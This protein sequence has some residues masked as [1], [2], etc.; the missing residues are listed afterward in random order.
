MN[1]YAW[2]SRTHQ[3]MKGRIVELKHKVSESMHVTGFTLVEMLVVL[4]MLSLLLGILVPGLGRVRAAARQTVCQSRLRQWAVAFEIYAAENNGFLPHADG[5]DRSGSTRPWT[6]EGRAD[7]DAGWVDVLPPLL[8]EKPWRE[9]ERYDYPGRSTVFQCPDTRLAPLDRYGYQPL[10]NGFFS[11]AM[12]SCL[13][14]DANCWPPYGSGE[15]NN[16]PSFLNTRLIKQPERVI[17]VFEQLL[18][19]D[20]GF[21]GSMR[22]RSAGKHCGGYPRAF[23][24]R[25]A[26]PGQVLGGNILFADSHVDWR[27]SVWKETW[28]QDFEFQAPPRDDP[29]W[30]PY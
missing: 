8:G 4:A 22:D 13:E 27:E 29:E 16:M 7:Y 15:G 26:K 24:A 9:Y 10:R 2:V 19:P 1:R 5:R 3:G 30:Y 6:D 28:P 12:N 17:L 21:G 11:Y 18:D 14:L 25:H 20:K 23:S